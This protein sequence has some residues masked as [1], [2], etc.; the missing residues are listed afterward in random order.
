VN[1]N[2]REGGEMDKAKV[3]GIGIFLTF[4]IFG[5]GETKK[6]TK[7]VEKELNP[8]KAPSG[9]VASAV[10]ESQIDLSWVDNSG[11]ESRLELWRKTEGEIWG[12]VSE[13]PADT[14]SYSDTGLEAETEYFYQIRACNKDGCSG[15]SEIASAITQQAPASPPNAPS[16]LSTSALSS[17]Q[18]LLTWQDNS[19]NEENFKVERSDG[20]GFAE[21]ATVL[22]NQTSYLDEGLS[23]DTTYT[24][25]VCACNSAG[26]SD[27]SQETQVQTPPPPISIPNPPSNLQ[28]T[29]IS[30]SQIDLVWQDNSDDETKFEVWRKVAGG[31]WGLVAEL[32]ANL[33]S[34]SDTG[35]AP[36]TE[37]FYQV[38]ACN[39]AGCSSF[40][41]VANATT[42]SAPLSAPNAPSG[43]SAS[44]LSSSQI[45]LTW[46]DNSDDEE[47]FKIERDDGSGF[48]EI[49]TVSANQ[50]SYLDEGLSPSTTYA[51]QI[52]AYNSAGESGYSNQAQATTFDLSASCQGYCGGQGVGGC[53]CDESCWDYGDCCPDVCD[54]CGICSPNC[55]DADGD[56][57]YTKPRCGTA[58]DCDDS[59][60]TIY[61]GAPEICDRKDNQC[62][63]DNGY[64]QIDEICYW[65]RTYGGT[66]TEWAEAIK[67]TSE[68]GYIVTGWTTT[69]GAGGEDIWILKLD[70]R[71]DVIWSIT[72]GNSV[73][74]ER[75]HWDRGVQQ[76]SDGGY[77][78]VGETNTHSSDSDALILKLD[79]DGNIIWSVSYGGTQRDTARSVQE[80]L[81]GGYIV[82]GW[83][84]SYGAGDY[85]VWILK[86]DLN[87]NLNWS[88]TFGDSGDDKAISIIQ[89]QDG[90]Y[91]V[92]GWTSS[93]GSGGVDVWVLKLDANGN[94]LWDK[95]FGGSAND[96][97]RAIIQESSGNYIIAGRTSSY[98]AGNIDVWI[99]K[100]DVNG[101]KIWD[102]TFGGVQNDYAS[103]IT[104]SRDGTYV[105]A[106]WTNSFGAGNWDILTIKVDSNA[107]II[108]FKTF[109]K[110]GSD[111]A[112]S[113]TSTYDGGYILA[114][115]TSS[116][117]A[118]GLDFWVLKLDANGD[119]PGCF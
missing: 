76:T 59:D 84:N 62:P 7:Y 12:L 119:C 67:Q 3:L 57:F 5:C 24:Y 49:A 16:G 63:G 103:S 53:W 19:D 31:V 114:G 55:V 30:S 68:G 18:V 98:G 104:E 32:N 56:G 48:I 73:N 118:G 13:L 45:L 116:Y 101:N 9:L 22:A 109:G 20:S 40:S 37:Y 44:A 82:A 25:W 83:T 26:C 115:L 54:V 108:G 93:Y 33:T 72:Y 91:A 36:D 27:Y 64:G 74:D 11:N 52:K 14:V 46:Q 117:G 113:I 1:T 88:K 10:S 81:D 94:R 17:S 78:V 50:T 8:P 87:G 70:S 4:L 96:D 100:L 61:P 80:T 34:F 79:S 29:S 66:K 102:K 60:S 71:G 112:Y 75:A 2:N 47:G 41:E 38:R 28:A 69:Y 39:S 43:L 105:V 15:F 111:N 95:T 77:I 110:A 97:G 107:N 92:A 99:L 21:I 35:L 6:E 90:G 42:Q 65:A 85:D 86:L 106:G 51:Y 89:T 23:G 58:V